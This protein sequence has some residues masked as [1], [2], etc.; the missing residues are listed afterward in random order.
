M[1]KLQLSSDTRKFRFVP[2][3]RREGSDWRNC[4]DSPPA[5]DAPP[6]AWIQTDEAFDKEGERRVSICLGQVGPV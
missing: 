4:D 5:T 6:P 2:D 1:W 3:W